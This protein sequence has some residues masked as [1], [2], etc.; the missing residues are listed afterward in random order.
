M[1]GDDI[2]R[3]EIAES[4]PSAYPVLV[5]YGHVLRELLDMLCRDEVLKVHAVEARAKDPSSLMD[6]FRRHPGYER[7]SDADDVCGVRIVTFYLADVARV[8]DLLHREFKIL[9]EETRQAV[10][11]DAFGYQ[12]LHVI[13]CLDDRRSSLPEYASYAEYRVEFQVRTVLQHAWGVISHSLDYK[14]EAE[15]PP[16]IR[17]KLFRV[18]ALLET[19]D[20][21]FASYRT[22][23]QDLRARYRSQVVADDWAGL[24]VDL[25]SVLA[26]MER[27]PLKEIAVAAKEA[28][29]QPPEYPM[30][31][32]APVVRSAVGRL[33]AVAGAVGIKTLGDL[34]AHMSAVPAHREQLAVLAR[35]SKQ[36]GFTP[37]ADPFDITVFAMLL[38]HPELRVKLAITFT[39]PIE[40]G[41][42]EV[43]RTR[44]AV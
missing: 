32:E 13:A 16:E 10:S 29:F 5:A 17:R 40:T 18:A 23:I 41:L 39:R 20:E 42:D 12:S 8:R 31:D 44:N 34:A 14:N 1:Y 22:E 4:Y 7:L 3:D 30:D 6:K 19:G 2:P 21:L 43:L 11:P 37:L 28:G 15:T 36:H 25:D 27:L 9:K 35:V 38:E 26:S 24:P 33:V